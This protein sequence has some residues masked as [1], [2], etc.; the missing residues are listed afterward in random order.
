MKNELQ[1]L[2]RLELIQYMENLL[3]DLWELS[4]QLGDTQ[5][6]LRI[7]ELSKELSE[8]RDFESDENNI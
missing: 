3:E 7:Q 5:I 2:P 1:H 6:D 8:L 4:K